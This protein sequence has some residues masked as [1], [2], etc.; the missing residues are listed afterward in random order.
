MF[1]PPNPSIHHL[2]VYLFTVVSTGQWQ[3]HSSAVLWRPD[4]NFSKMS[5]RRCSL[6][7]LIRCMGQ[8][9]WEPPTSKRSLHGPVHI[10]V[11]L[12]NPSWPFNLLNWS[13]IW[14][15]LNL[16]ADCQPRAASISLAQEWG[17]PKALPHSST[18]Q[19]TWYTL[20]S[21]SYNQV[22]TSSGT[23]TAGASNLISQ[24]CLWQTSCRCERDSNSLAML[25]HSRKISR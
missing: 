7:H 1:E 17:H 19:A 23:Q 22:P 25:W 12:V 20:A 14:V 16:S 9:F 24:T 10:M 15:N 11:N 8:V 6:A 4:L 2:K 13:T 21:Y 5:L 18:K 3:G